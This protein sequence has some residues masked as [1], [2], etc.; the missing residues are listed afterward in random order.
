MTSLSAN[1]LDPLSTAPTSITLDFSGPIDL[2]NLFLVDQAEDAL[3]LVDSTGN[4]WPITAESYD[5]S[6]HQLTMVIDEP[7]PAGTYRLFSP[8]N[9]P[10]TDLAGEPVVAAGGPTGVL[11][12]FAVAAPSGQ[13]LP[14]DLGVLWPNQIGVTPASIGDT[15]AGTLYLA[16]GQAATYRFVAIVT[17]LY[18]LQTVMASGSISVEQLG[19]G[20]MKTLD[21]GSAS[22]INNYI[23]KLVDGVY[24]I[25]FAD[26]GAASSV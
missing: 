7:L 2:S 24:Q 6:D 4:V 10:L 23:M 8:A 13:T 16:P 9:D 22:S 21:A 19:P 14:G 26:I 11:E 12:T 15:L 20:G 17:G 5:I 1:W 18:Q 3:E 25:Q